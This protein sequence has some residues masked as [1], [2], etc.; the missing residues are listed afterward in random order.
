MNKLDPHFGAYTGSATADTDNSIS[1][2]RAEVSALFWSAKILE[3]LRHPTASLART[4]L[5]KLAEEMRETAD[6]LDRI[7]DRA[8]QKVDLSDFWTAAAE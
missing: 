8:E 1:K 4:D 3:G 7:V 2:I 6:M 5:R